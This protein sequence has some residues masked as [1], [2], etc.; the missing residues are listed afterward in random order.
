M[1]F[2]LCR[3]STLTFCCSPGFYQIDFKA[4]LIFIVF[5]HRNI[6]SISRWLICWIVISSGR[7]GC[8]AID[9]SYANMSLYLYLLPQIDYSSNKILLSSYKIWDFR[10]H[11][12]LQMNNRSLLTLIYGPA[13]ICMHD[14]HKQPNFISRN[15]MLLCIIWS[16][17]ELQQGKHRHMRKS[18]A[19]SD[20][21]CW[22]SYFALI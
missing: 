6:Q 22:L 10:D 19:N 8:D 4:I 7:V 12:R 1:E 16:L 2:S 14:T 9:F 3:F 13:H 21:F 5:C 18:N 20:I 15:L 11:N 17:F